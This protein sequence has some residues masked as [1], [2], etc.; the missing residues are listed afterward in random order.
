[1]GWFRGQSRSIRDCPLFLVRGFSEV[2]FAPEDVAR[3]K[4]SHRRWNFRRDRPTSEALRSKAAAHAKSA[5]GLDSIAVLRQNS[6][7]T[8][9]SAIPCRN[10]CPIEVILSSPERQDSLPGEPLR[11]VPVYIKEGSR[12]F[13]RPWFGLSSP[14]VPVVQPSQ[15]RMRKDV[16]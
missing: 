8:E 12:T 2:P 15:S 14:I 10:R 4:L 6:M 1:M 7:R 13:L 5:H 11:G 16:T 3:V 9:N